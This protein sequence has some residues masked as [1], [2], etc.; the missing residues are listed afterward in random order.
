MQPTKTTRI[1]RTIRRLFVRPRIQQVRRSPL[2][3]SLGKFERNIRFELQSIPRRVPPPNYDVPFVVTVFRCFPGIL[4]RSPQP[5]IY[6][7]DVVRPAHCP[8]SVALDHDLM[9]YTLAYSTLP[10][11]FLFSAI[12]RTAFIKS[13][14]RSTRYGT[15]RSAD[16][17]H[18]KADVIT[19]QERKHVFFHIWDKKHHR[20][21][22]LNESYQKKAVAN[23]FRSTQL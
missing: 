7:D 12:F 6:G 21:Q 4:V 2:V 1:T 8:F 16:I 14:W 17:K 19:L 9:P 20:I 11:S 18:E 23:H 10:S 3:S 5:S 22:P 15:M 13:S